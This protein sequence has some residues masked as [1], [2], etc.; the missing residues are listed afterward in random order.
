MPTVS[1]EYFGMTGEGRTVTEAKRNAGAKIEQALSGDYAPVVLEW[2]GVGML[3]YREPS[4][5]GSKIIYD[6]GQLREGTVYA[7]CCYHDKKEAIRQAYDHLSR[8]GVSVDDAPD[9]APD[10]LDAQQR[11]E[12][13]RYAEFQRR[14]HTGRAM[15][16]SDDDA[17]SY[18][19]RNP[20]RRELWE[21]AA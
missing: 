16:L 5:W 20:A 13:K 7:H 9:F 6:E 18:A 21:N 15:G 4:G 1:I 17:H 14:Y 10:F 8:I 11:N 3:V 12:Y 2:R 19:G